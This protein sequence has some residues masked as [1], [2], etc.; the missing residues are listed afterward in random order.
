M[1]IF[2]QK[3]TRQSEG[4]V[5]ALAYLE[6]AQRLRT[7]LT[8]LAPKGRQAPALLASVSE[9]RVTLTLQGPL[10][11]ERGDALGLILHL[12]G[13]RLKVA[14]ALLE[15]KP[16][17]AVLEAPEGIA[18]AERRKKPRARL[19]AREGATA[20]A[21][22]GL[23]DGIGVSGP[24][25]NISEGGV[26][27]RVERA[28]DVKTQRKMHLGPNLLS[29]GQALML[30]KLTKLPKCPTLELTGVV[31]YLDADR[32]GLCLGVT[33]ESGKESLLSPVRQLVASR[34]GSIPS[35]VPPKSRRSLEEPAAEPEAKGPV[36]LAAPSRPEP[37]PPA[38]APA[39]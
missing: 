4:S 31:A 23:F 34:A 7:P 2:G 27:I 30:V 18:L 25:E 9:E 32:D 12:D 36:E 15:V 3:K 8:V 6:E 1:A 35:S 39:P 17:S 14:T 10:I 11:A 20:T 28:M 19:S 38:E 33:F 21:L 22:T 24:I 13:L 37:R 29:V 26:R 5:L 16:G